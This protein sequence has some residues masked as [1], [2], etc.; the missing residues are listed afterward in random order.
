MFP[1][2]YWILLATIGSSAPS[3]ARLAAQQ[4]D[5]SVEKKFSPS[6]LLPSRSMS[7]QGVRVGGGG[8]IPPSP[9]AS[10]R[11]SATAPPLLSRGEMAP[12]EEEKM[13]TA[14][15]FAFERNSS[16]PQPPLGSGRGVLHHHRY[17]HQGEG[18]TAS[19]TVVNASYK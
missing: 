18:G 12:R 4:L 15:T 16:N 13:R 17:C 19:L 14:T 5:V 1:V 3:T 6:L 7:A 9:S 11:R 8:T 10:R 2:F